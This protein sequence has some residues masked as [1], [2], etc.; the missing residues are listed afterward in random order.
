M[1]GVNR[2]DRTASGLA[3]AGA[4]RYSACGRAR[5]ARIKKVHGI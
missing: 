1:G 3:K 2:R 5:E 4:N